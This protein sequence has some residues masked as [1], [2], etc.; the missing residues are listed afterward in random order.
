MVAGWLMAL[1][2]AAWAHSFNVVMVVPDDLAQGLRDDMVAAF[3]VASEER[4]G[5]ANEE[6]DGHLGGLDVY[7]TLAAMGDRAR[8]GAAG[9]DIL[10]LPLAGDARSGDAVILRAMDVGSPQATGFLN[11]AAGV[12]FAP[13][14]DRF[15]DRAGRAP[16]AEATAAYL[17]ARRIDLAVRQLQSVDDRAKLADLLK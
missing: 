12:D 5:H 17:A 16:G 10:A 13:F 8:I 7:I 2:P 1:A 15:A 11:S 6:S 4:D 14:A 9:P 3:L